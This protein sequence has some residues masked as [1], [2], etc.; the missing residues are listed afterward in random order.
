MFL[1]P[2]L[3]YSD[4][5]NVSSPNSIAELPKHSNINNYPIN[6]VDNK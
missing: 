1:L 5:T 6:L 3:I 2:S 4:H